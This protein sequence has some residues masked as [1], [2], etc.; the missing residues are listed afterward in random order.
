MRTM[1][2]KEQCERR[3]WEMIQNG[4][5][6]PNGLKIKHTKSIE[7]AC[8]AAKKALKEIEKEMKI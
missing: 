6:N 5:L 7:D 8:E 3:I 4:T 1:M 2:T